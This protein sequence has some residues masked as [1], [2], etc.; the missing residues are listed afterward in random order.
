MS[1]RC[2]RCGEYEAEGFAFCG[3]CGKDLGPVADSEPR[4]ESASGR[5]SRCNEYEA[6]GFAFC[7]GCGNNLKGFDG[8]V[9][10]SA[11]P[12]PP[13]YSFLTIILSVVCVFV[14]FIA[15]FEALA[16]VVNSGDVFNFLSDK[17]SGFFMLLPFP[18]VVFSLQELALQLYWMIIVFIILSCVA[19]T[20]MKFASAAKK[21]GGIAKHDNV[22]KTSAFWTG[23][24]ISA[25]IFINFVVVF[26]TLMLGSD[27]TTPDFG[28]KL[29]QMFLLAD[30]A[31]WEEIVTRLL[32]IGVPMAIIS[33][34][35]TKRI[36]SLKCVFGGFE[37]STAAV[38]LIVIS[39]AIFGMAH[40]GGWDDQAWKVLT[41]GIMGAFLGYVFVRF[42]LYASILLHFITNYLS[43]FDWMGI[44]GFE[45]AVTLCLLA[46][47]AV[48]SYYLLRRIVDSREAIKSLPMFRNGY[49]K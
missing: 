13:K 28:D 18:E 16:L 26:V 25:M 11:E 35:V 31:F 5:C 29:E 23:V 3:G 10:R 49:V 38:V 20:I 41:S 22:E 32:Y 17:T 36:E 14:L 27:V 12:E 30:A 46:A 43:S 6:E 9:P 2:P 19:T 33:L 47:G 44:G 45:V 8:P 15:L 48:A 39:S 24:F 21:P 40:Y 37:M 7:G 34:A 1:E 4:S 42:G